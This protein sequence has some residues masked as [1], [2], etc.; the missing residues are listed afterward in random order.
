MPALRELV[1]KIGF[2]VDF[3]GL[4]RAEVETD[5]FAQGFAEEFKEAGIKI[6]REIERIDQSIRGIH[7]PQIDASQSINEIQ[8]LQN[9]VEELRQELRRLEQQGRDTNNTLG[10]IDFGAL[11]GAG[12]AGLALGVMQDVDNSAADIQAQL[13]ITRKEAEVLRGVAIDVFKDNFADSI[14]DA[15]Q[16][17]VL[18]NRVTG[19]TN[20][21]L[22][23]TAKKAFLIREAF[24]DASAD[25]R[26]IVDATRAVAFTMEMDFDR[27]LDVIAT[28]FVKNLNISDDWLDTAREFSPSFKRIGADAEKMLA[29]IRTGLDLGIRDT[30]RMADSINEFGIL[31]QEGDNEGLF[32]VAKSIAK[33]DRAAQKLVKT[34]Q[35]DFA[36]GGESAARVT[37]E[38][39]KGLFAIKDPLK[40]NEYGIKLFGT[41]WEDTA[42][43]VGKALL[44]AQGKEIELLN[45]TE[46]L[47]IKHETAA[48]RIKGFGRSLLGDIIAPLEDF[49]PMLN[50]GIQGL[51]SLGM[52]LFAAQGFGL[53]FG[54]VMT[55]V[56]TAV[57]FALG[58]IGL[59]ITA[60]GLIGWAVK[61]NWGL[62]IEYTG[63]LK[64]RWTT[65]WDTIR[66]NAVENINEVIDGLNW[67][68]EKINLIPGI[69]IGTIHKI[70]QDAPGGGMHIPEPPGLAYGGEVTR[71]GLTLVG[72]RGP[73]LLHLPAGAQV[74]PLPAAATGG[75]TYT[76]NIYAPSGDARDIVRE[77]DNYF[78]RLAVK[79]PQTTER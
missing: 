55:A 22:E 59:A 38:I 10:N 49:G 44:E 75:D 69:K 2:K 15:T 76:I 79:R 17:V 18:L 19:K 31:V 74:Q 16:G 47:G 64:Q 60:I 7:D 26:E 54:G 4:R 6:E 51:T 56:G 5:R 25:I 62:I 30:D 33:T 45:A 13:A 27:A 63:T 28:G 14:T 53:T 57:R 78:R 66:N 61:E 23:K 42:G 12:G 48:E 37:N 72:E 43:A 29:I 36:R 50:L 58:P 8:R 9:E 1:N 11:A 77:I 70:G 71:S 52:A 65:F 24:P 40:R 46:I 39:V 20:E 21:E 73:E 32:N 34:W 41:M 3:R 67:L 68:I 35:K